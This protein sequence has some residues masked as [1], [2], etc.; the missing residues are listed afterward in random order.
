MYEQ[1]IAFSNVTFEPSP[2][3]NL[4]GMEYGLYLPTGW[5]CDFDDFHTEHVI[6]IFDESDPRL[7]RH[8]P[9]SK[10]DFV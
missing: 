4:V 2:G 5:Q 6:V 1:K 7:V 9:S 8:E 3:V 10:P